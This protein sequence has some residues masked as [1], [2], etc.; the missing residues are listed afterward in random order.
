LVRR[1]NSLATPGVDFINILLEA[2]TRADPKSEKTSQVVS[3]FV[4]LGSVCIKAAR[5]MLVKSTP[6]IDYLGNFVNAR[7]RQ[8]PSEDKRI[9]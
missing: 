1:Q 7:F 5:K 9:Q 2:F 8:I 6:G 4:L 3:L